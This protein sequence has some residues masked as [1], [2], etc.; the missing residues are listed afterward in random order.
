MR[1]VYKKSYICSVIC[2][3]KYILDCKYVFGI[4]LIDQGPHLAIYRNVC[5]HTLCK[6]FFIYN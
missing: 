3:L 1:V 5:V 2:T 6:Y 4:G